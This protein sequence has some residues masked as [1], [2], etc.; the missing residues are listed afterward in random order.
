MKTRAY[1]HIVR[2]TFI[3]LL[4]SS[5]MTYEIAADESIRGALA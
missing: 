1:I 3:V 4:P 5:R 2:K